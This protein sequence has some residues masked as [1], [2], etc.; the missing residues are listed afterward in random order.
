MDN[1]TFTDADFVV[2]DRKSVELLGWTF[3]ERFGMSIKEMI[4][5]PVT[6]K[7]KILEIKK[8]AGL[9]DRIKINNIMGFLDDPNWKQLLKDKLA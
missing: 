7:N 2:M 1:T 9:V 4:D 3:K 6:G 8:N 5:D